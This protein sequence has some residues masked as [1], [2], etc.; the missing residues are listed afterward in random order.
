[1]KLSKIGPIAYFIFAPAFLLYL[2]FGDID[3]SS[4]FYLGAKV[5]PALFSLIVVFLFLGAVLSKKS[6]TL[7]LTQKFY[8]KKLN[9]KEE[10]FLAK[11]DSYWLGVTFLN[12][13]ILFY[14][15]LYSDNEIWA[16]YSSV[17]VYI[18]LLIALGLQILYGIS[19]KINQETTLK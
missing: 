11:S 4:I 8:R 14:L 1:M 6:L 12:S 17:G 10:I 2:R 15:G 18:Y 16:T 7:T 3:E 9:V 19:K 5:V 13:S